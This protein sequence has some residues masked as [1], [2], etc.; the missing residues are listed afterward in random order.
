MVT[1]VIGAKKHSERLKS[2]AG[3]A[4]KVLRALYV[5]GQNIELTAENSITRGSV[6][7]KGHVP[8]KPGEPPNADTRLLDTSIETTIESRMP[9]TVAVTSNAPHSAALEFGTSKMAERP[10]MRPATK[11]NR[12]RAVDLVKGAVFTGPRN[13]PSPV[14]IGPNPKAP[15]P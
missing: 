15:K 4:P 8:S 10:F 3:V 9:P 14:S 2:L 13:M 12:R 11:K 6:S 1:Y 5:A 7:G